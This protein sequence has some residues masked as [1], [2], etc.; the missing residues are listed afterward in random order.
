MSKH[1]EYCCG[2]YFDNPNNEMDYCKEC[3]D[4]ELVKS[5]SNAV[6]PS[7]YVEGCPYYE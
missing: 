4:C 2:C 5:K 6:Q 7:N 1:Q 3:W